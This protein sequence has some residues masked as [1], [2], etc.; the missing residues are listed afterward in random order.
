[1]LLIFGN[2]IDLFTNRTF[3][4][5]TLNFTMLSTFCPSGVELTAENFMTE[6]KYVFNVFLSFESIDYY[7]LFR[8]CD[9]SALNLTIPNVDFLNNVRQQSVWLASKY[10]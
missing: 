6:Y 7:G 8:K 1:M 10:L 4:V 9:F 5:C 3:N 2:V